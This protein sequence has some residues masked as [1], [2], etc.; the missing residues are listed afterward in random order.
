MRRRRL[1]E[2][3]FCMPLKFD[4]EL[5]WDGSSKSG[6]RAKVDAAGPVTDGTK[7]KEIC[8]WV[9]QDNGRNSAAATE[10]TTENPDAFDGSV[11]GRWRLELSQISETPL[12]NGLAFGVAVALLEKDGGQEQVIWWGHPLELVP[13]QGPTGTATAQHGESGQA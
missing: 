5:Q 8:A 1:L 13:R 9:F 2:E 3:V 10:M 7:I 6:G 4:D 12:Q 11:P